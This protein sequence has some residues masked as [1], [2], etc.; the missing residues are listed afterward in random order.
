ML[1]HPSFPFP[2]AQ[3]SPTPP[4]QVLLLLLPAD[5]VAEATNPSAGLVNSPSP[6]LVGTMARRDV[7]D[8]VRLGAATR[9]PDCESLLMLATDIAHLAV[10]SNSHMEARCGV[11]GMGWGVR[12]C[13]PVG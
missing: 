10:V 12:F 13:F 9:T 4:L 7:A 3:P 11:V 6:V 2:I 8:R 1:T 5:S